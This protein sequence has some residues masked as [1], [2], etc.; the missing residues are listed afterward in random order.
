MCVGRGTGR[1]VRS[2][3]R[4]H[5]RR[6]TS[7]RAGWPV[8][9]PLR[10][11]ARRQTSGPGVTPL[12]VNADT[13]RGGR[14]RTWSCTSARDRAASVRTRPSPDRA[15]GPR[16]RL[17]GRYGRMLDQSRR[18]CRGGRRDRDARQ[19]AAEDDAHVVPAAGG[20][21]VDEAVLH[22]AVLGRRT[23]VSG[24]SRSGS[25][26]LTV[27]AR[28]ERLSARTAVTTPTRPDAPSVSPAIDF[29][30]LTAA[31]SPNS[32]EIAALPGDRCGARPPRPRRRS[33][34]RGG[35]GRFAPRRGASPRA[36]RDSRRR[37]RR[38]PR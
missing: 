29:G 23:W 2:G 22:L 19:S 4:L 11:T 13:L 3:D 38:P 14:G 16:C 28:I 15:L 35:R 7:L 10:R 1:P 6:T 31:A 25:P 18:W 5:S 32:R 24:R 8:V 33:R 26:R 9:A 27:G 21:G 20:G 30:A 17:V 36:R 37:S 34:H 12:A